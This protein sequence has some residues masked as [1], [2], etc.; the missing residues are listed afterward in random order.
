MAGELVGFV[1]SHHYLGKHLLN[2][3]AMGCMDLDMLDLTRP[4]G[5][6]LEER[7]EVLEKGWASQVAQG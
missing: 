4:F 1:I 2:A 7:S 6:F 3:V 5:T